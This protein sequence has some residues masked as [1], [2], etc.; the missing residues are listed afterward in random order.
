M[1]PR[2]IEMAWVVVNDLPQAKEFFTK[3]LGM[4][5]EADSPESNWAEVST[6]EGTV[7]IGI[8]ANCKDSAVKAGQ[9]AVICINVDD[10]VAV[11]KE[12]EAKNV[13]VIGDICEVPGHVKMI[14]I[15]DPSGNYYNL[16]QR[17]Y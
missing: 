7:R 12:L 14:L 6:G 17:L 16:V 3:I 2:S 15:Q 13:P 10:V 1:K 8:G 9:N 11:K 5:L 4:K